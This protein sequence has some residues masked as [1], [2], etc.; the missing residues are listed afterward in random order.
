MYELQATSQLTL[1]TSH[2]TWEALSFCGQAIL[3]RIKTKICKN[4][5]TKYKAD[6]NLKNL[7]LEVPFVSYAAQRVDMLAS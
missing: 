1:S 5:Y 6:K 4:K 7:V 2:F 3:W